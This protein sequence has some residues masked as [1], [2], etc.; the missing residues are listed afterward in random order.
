MRILIIGGTRFMGPHIIKNLH[1]A[2]HEVAFFHRGQT[3]TELPEGVREILG[4]RDQ[5]PEYASELRTWQ[6]DVVLDMVVWNEQHARDLMATFAGNARRAIV[7][8]SQDVYRSFGRVN[9]HE[10]GEVD[11]SIITEDSPLRENLY[12]YRSEPLRAE[13]DPERWRDTYDKI[14]AERVVMNHPELPGTILRLPAVYGPLDNQHRMF[15][16]LK[17]MLDGRPAILLEEDLANWRWTHGYV[18]NIA[19][20]IALAVTDERASGHI[21]NLGEPFTLNVTERVE[22]IA[23]AANWHG[24]IITLPTE[25]VPEGTRWGINAAQNI[26][27]D[28]SSFRRHLGYS[29][30]IDLTEAFR[31]TIAWESANPPAKID[32]TMFDYEAEDKVLAKL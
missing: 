10:G 26:V 14:P 13:D 30:R 2:G 20:A 27:V 22:Q 12:P 28:S 23:K 31:R 15:P 21:Y 8:S 24:R 25:R 29:E 3:S 18:E 9:Q 32:P 19:D 17:R 1:A 6:P 11:P 4:D 5:L 7:L 16:Y